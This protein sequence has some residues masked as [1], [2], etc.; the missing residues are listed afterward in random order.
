MTTNEIHIDFEKEPTLPDVKEKLEELVKTLGMDGSPKSGKIFECSY[1]IIGQK[2]SAVVLSTPEECSEAIHDLK[3]TVDTY[4]EGLNYVGK[5]GFLNEKAIK[6]LNHETAKYN[7]RTTIF[8]AI[9]LI[10]N[11]ITLLVNILA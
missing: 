4:T 1:L 9:A 3:Q 2:E 10:A 5:K 11:I 7:R 6:E 8:L